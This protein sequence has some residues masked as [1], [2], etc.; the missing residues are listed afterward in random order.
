MSE[1]LDLDLD[2]ADRLGF[3]EIVY[4]EFKSAD[5]LRRIAD[6]HRKRGRGMLAT[7]LV[8]AQVEALGDFAVD[9]EPKKDDEAFG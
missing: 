6:V 7:R 3:P 5:Q 8:P 2:R 9:A 1:D 4:G